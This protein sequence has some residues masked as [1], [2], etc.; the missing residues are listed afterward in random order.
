MNQPTEI[1]L[2]TNN[3]GKIREF[4]ILFADLGIKFR[5]LSD[6]P[7]VSE[8][9]ETGT[10]FTENA[11][12]KAREYALATN[13]PTIADD[14]GLEV[15]ALGGAPGVFSARYGGAGL[16]DAE[17]CGKLLADLEKNADNERA[18]RFICVIAVAQSNGEIMHS[19]DGICP[20]SISV[21]PC[22]T[23]GFGYDAV[24]VPDGYEQTFGELPNEI[25]RQ[26]SHRAQ[27]VD[28]IVRFLHGFLHIS[29][30]QAK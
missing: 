17:R 7:H 20:G 8:V 12:L 29:L 5:R 1:L 25:K 18:A 15:F 9:A 2:A 23:N 21:N 4:E 27:A 13:L 19:A 10:T 14:S 28:K 11:A 30:D 3:T 16:S 6:F 26:I 22:G 24:F